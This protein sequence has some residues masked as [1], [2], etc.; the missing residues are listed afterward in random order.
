MSSLE[1]VLEEE[2]CALKRTLEHTT[3]EGQGEPV[4]RCKNWEQNLENL[5]SQKSLRWKNS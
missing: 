4:K 2:M 1:R 3:R 5:K